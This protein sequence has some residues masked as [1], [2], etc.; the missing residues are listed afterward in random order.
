MLQL[1]KRVL[2]W[3]R[4]ETLKLLILAGVILLV[5]GI[6]APVGTLVWGLG[7]GA[8]SLGVSSE[9]GF[10]QKRP[11]NLPSQPEASPGGNSNCYTVFLP[12]I[13]DFS[14]DEL[15]SGQT[16]F[17]DHLFKLH[18]HCVMVR[19]VFPYSVSNKSLG[20]QGLLAPLWRFAHEADE[21]DSWIGV[22]DVLIKIRNLW[23][24][25]IAADPRYGPIYNA[26]I[27]TAII[28]RMAAMQPLPSPQKPLK[29]ILLGTSGGV[30]VALGAAPYLNQWLKAKITIVSVGGVFDGRQGFNVT[31]HFYHLRGRQDWVQNIGGI[32]FPSRWQWNVAS[33]FNV[34]RLHSRYTAVSS[35]P[36]DHDGP[37]G[38]FG[39]D[40]A[41]ANDTYVDLTL[42]AVNQLPIWSVEDSRSAKYG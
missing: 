25:A 35:G 24:F 12:G 10:K 3:L 18:P 17:L 26:G 27:A 21:A 29:I 31:E 14:G 33:P 28:E 34:A 11:K 7:Q 13:G 40:V 19:D 9:L 22:A 30:E 1:I 8:E 39:E 16:V 36:H 20:G 41:K 6:T 5:W 42:Q 15:T 23:R 32:V 2:A 38:Y 37:K 4:G